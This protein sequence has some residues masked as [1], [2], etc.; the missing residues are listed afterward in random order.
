VSFLTYT[1]RI[2]RGRWRLSQKLPA[3]AAKGGQLSIQYT[4][5]LRG[6]IAGAQTAKQVV[7][8]G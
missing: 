7:P 3:A 2:D 8:S 4:G 5:S 6:R 1:A